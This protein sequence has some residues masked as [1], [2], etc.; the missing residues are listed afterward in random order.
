MCLLLRLDPGGVCVCV[1]IIHFLVLL[2]LLALVLWRVY[3]GGASPELCCVHFSFY[4]L[5]SRY[6]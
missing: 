2:S 1:G 5:R 3:S 6:F 4:L